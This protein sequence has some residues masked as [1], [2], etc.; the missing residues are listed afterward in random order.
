MRIAPKMQIYKKQTIS[1]AKIFV[2]HRN[3]EA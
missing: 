3:A 2:H 1:T